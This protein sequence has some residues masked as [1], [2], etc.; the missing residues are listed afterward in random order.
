MSD[1][2]KVTVFFSGGDEPFICHANGV[3]TIEDLQE[4]EREIASDFSDF[5]EDGSY[6]FNCN[7]YGGLIGE[8]GILET[9]S[10]W[11]LSLEAFTPVS[12][13]A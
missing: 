13:E 2:L 3:C 11:D 8:N 6:T 4:I 5:N 7:W 1:A 9:P 10:G 12:E